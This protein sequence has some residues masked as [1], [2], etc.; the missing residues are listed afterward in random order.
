M[1]CGDGR[2]DPFEDERACAA[3]CPRGC[4]DGLCDPSESAS[5][6]VT[7]CRDECGDGWCSASE[8]TARGSCPEDCDGRCFDAGGYSRRYR[9]CG[10]GRCEQAS[11]C[12]YLEPETCA[13]CPRDCGACEWTVTELHREG[14][15]L[16]FPDGVRVYSESDVWVSTQAT[17][18]RLLFHYDG[19]GWRRSREVSGMGIWGARSGHLV[20][21]ADPPQVLEAGAWSEM[22]APR[23]GESLGV[24]GRAEDEVYQ[25][26]EY[27]VLYYDG[28]VWTELGSGAPRGADVWAS[29][30]DDVYV[31]TEG[32]QLHHFDGTG[33]TELHP[34]AVGGSPPSGARSADDVLAAGSDADS[35]RVVR[36]DGSAWT[37]VS[38]AGAGAVVDLWSTPTSDLFAL[39]VEGTLLRYDGAAWSSFPA[40][41]PFE[42]R[43][44]SGS[45]DDVIFGVGFQGERGVI[46]RFDGARWYELT[47][48][49]APELY[50]GDVWGTGADDVR[51]V[52]GGRLYHFDGTEL[53]YTTLSTPPPTRPD[54]AAVF[55]FATGELFVGGVYL[56]PGATRPDARTSLRRQV[57]GS[58]TEW[59]FSGKS[60][61]YELWGLAPD[62]LFA[63]GQTYY[64]LHFDGSRFTRYDFPLRPVRRRLGIQRRRR[65]H[66]GSRRHPALRHLTLPRPDH[67]RAHDGGGRSSGPSGE[68]APR[69]CSRRETA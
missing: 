18:G 37:D 51:M 3:D 4:G 27:G 9:V 69:T 33:W 20:A 38:P 47:G 21:G 54:F 52:V 28:S 59:T 67:V 11:S 61:I 62:H 45:A 23:V 36:F 7:D 35:A 46:Q 8:I 19:A 26:S 16:G 12:D 24:F 43:A 1:R 49:T 40:A 44:L 6:C 13:S 15:I 22:V 53:S 58:W 50:L 68:P 39:D 34:R 14:Q 32:G 64:V 17:N 2:C 42:A 25:A 55:G 31:A 66:R 63:F 41:A 57:G 56:S 5:T 30:P 10:D 65:V 60:P 29:G 48:V